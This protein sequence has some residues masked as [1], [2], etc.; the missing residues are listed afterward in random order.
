MGSSV[1][2]ILSFYN[3]TLVKENDIIKGFFIISSDVTIMIFIIIFIIWLVL[4]MNLKFQKF[5]LKKY[6]N[7]E[8]NDDQFSIS[9]E[10]VQMQKSSFD[11]ISMLLMLAN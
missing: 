9:T 4:S 5:N 1:W 2:K 6:T 7:R 11:M 8:S 3:E 10:Q